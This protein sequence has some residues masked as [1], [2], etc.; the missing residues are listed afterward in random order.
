MLTISLSRSVWTLTGALS[1]GP[2][3]AAT[4]IKTVESN[5]H[6]SWHRGMK[7]LAQHHWSVPFSNLNFALFGWMHY[8]V[9]QKK[10]LSTKAPP[11]IIM[12]RPQIQWND[13][14]SNQNVALLWGKALV[15]RITFG[16][17]PSNLSTAPPANLLGK[18]CF[19]NVTGGNGKS[20]TLA[21]CI[22]E[23]VWETRT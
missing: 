13:L 14:K 10:M 7:S 12:R 15:K 11:I 17:H 2:W 4:P 23:F 19:P 6:F 5:W 22:C 20:C 18:H 21:D 9:R 1:W 16:S 3:G 8:S